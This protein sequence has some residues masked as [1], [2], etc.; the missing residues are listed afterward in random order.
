[1]DSTK[2]APNQIEIEFKLAMAVPLG[3][4]DEDYQIDPPTI[5]KVLQKVYLSSERERY[6]QESALEAQE[7]TGKIIDS[8]EIYEV[9][10][11][12]LV[13]YRDHQGNLTEHPYWVYK[14]QRCNGSR[15]V[16]EVEEQELELAT[17]T[18]DEEYCW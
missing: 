9:V 15:E 8:P 5:T 7:K 13:F 18:E 3:D 10:G 6:Y 16:I 1:M 12:E 17:Q 11:F 14:L 2:Q 4:P